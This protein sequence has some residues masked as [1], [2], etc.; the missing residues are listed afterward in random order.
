MEQKKILVADDE[1]HILR[2]VKD[3]LANAGFTVVTASNGEEALETARREKPSLV[4]LDV[5]MPKMN[6]FDVCRTLRAE[7]EF[8][9]VPILLLTARGQEIDRHM[10]LEAGASEYITKPFSPRELL[11]TVQAQL[12]ASKTA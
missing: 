12:E 8:K 5:M 4:L 2:V 11:A 9:G 10:G 6:G 7:A 1:P 3:K